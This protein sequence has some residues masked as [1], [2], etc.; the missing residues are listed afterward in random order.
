M[1]DA[2]TVS[3]VPL[4]GANYPTWK[5]QCRMALIRDGL[6]GI[7]A[8][9]EVPPPE[10]NA[11]KYAK[12]MARRDRAL[13]IIVL[14]VDPSLLYLIGDPE[15]PKTVWEK[16]SG[17]FQKKTWANKLS[18][19]KKLF[20]MKLSDSGSMREYIKRM[21]EAFDELAVVADPVSDEDK[22]VYLLAGLPENYDVLVTAL[23]SGSDT[24]P[25]LE[26]VTERLLR[27][28]QKLKDRE[29]ADDGKKLLVAAGRKKFTCHYCKKPG[30]FKKDCWKFAQAQS[31]E[32][33]GRQRNPSRQS[34]KGQQS[35]HN[36]MVIGNALVARS[37]NDW[38][39]DSGATSHMCN[40][41]SMFMDLKQAETDEKVVLGDGN[42]LK[43]A[44]EGTID[45]DMLLDDG[46]T[47]GCALNRVLYV[48]ELAYNLVS[49]SRAAE[50]GKTVHFDDSGCEFRDQHGEV[51]ALGARQG[52]LYYLK[53]A[54]KSQANLAQSENKERLW[55][56]RFGHLNEQSMQK[57]VRRKLVNHLDYDTSGKIGVCEACIGGKQC[58]NSFKPS[59]TATSMPLELV[60]SDVCGKMGQKSIGGAEYFLTLLDDKTHYAWVYPLKTKDQVFERFKE[61]QAEVENFTGMKIKALRTDNG[62]EYTSKAFQAHLKACGIRHEL[63]IPKTPE[64]NGVAERLNRT[65]VETTRAMLLDANLPHKFWAEAVS[66]AVYLRN[67]SPSSA[68]VGTTPHQAWYGQKPR[69]EHLR[70]FGCTAF[71]HIPKDERGKLDSKTRKCILLGYGSVQKGYRVFDHLTQ[72]TSYSRNVKFDERESGGS[73]IEE[74][75]SAQRPLTLEPADESESDQD[76]S[77]EEGTD[78]SENS[79]AV[80]ETPL[81][82]STRERRPVDYYGLPQAH[83]TIHSEP[84]TYDEAINCPEKAKWKNAMGKEMQSLKANGVWELTTLPP[85]K[86]AISCKWVYKVKTN[87]DG[88]IERYKARLV[89]RGFDQKFGSDYDETFCPVIRMESLR[90]L[91]ALSTQR[92]LKLHHVDID[93]AFLNGT[94]EEEVYM[95]QP[96]GYEE[97]KEEHLVCRLKKSIYGLK[98]S[99]RC[100]NT[101]LDAH[102]KDMGFTQL[103]SDPCIYVSGEGEDTFYIGVYVDDLA[104]AGKNEAHMKCVKEELSS[105]F[106]IKDLGELKYFLGMSVVQDQEKKET[107]LGQPAHTARLLTKMGMSD[108]KP[109]KTPTDPSHHLVKATEAE[110]TLDQRLYQSLVGSLMYL[111][112]CTRP[113]IA[114][115]V[116][117]LARFSSKPNQ[118][119]WVAAKRVLRYLKGTSNLG[120]LFRGSEPGSC[121]AYADADWAG[122]VEDRKSTSGYMFLIAGGPVSW[123]SK[124]Q[125]TVALSTAEAEYVALSSATQECVWMRRLNSE[126]GNPPEGPT[127]ILEDNQ[128]CIAMAR[129]PQFHGRAKHI[130][131]KHH[132]VR[133]QLSSGKIELQY[134]PTHEM[135][136]DMLTK[137]LAQQQFCYLREKAGVVPLRDS[138]RTEP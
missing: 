54:R 37:R 136:A 117:T 67:R 57:L 32:K 2:R 25:A 64:Q 36:A 3:I 79:P 16:L 23:E 18:L 61:W 29:D 135:V 88:S 49:V 60:H 21:T 42:S 48:P 46:V 101:A 9:T 86:K 55:H 31:G 85:G 26:N 84:T 69:V 5:V 28:E 50:S 78:R 90:T 75:E 130:D 71:V 73:P 131:I 44:G 22:V 94:L 10:T 119:H 99:S 81:R 138:E 20:T 124:K 115:A 123:R 107:W 127:T 108:C 17:Q 89:A 45:M 8:G 109:V 125:D 132:F 120:I 39:V 95:E 4:N 100:W 111:A 106:D 97:G 70:V 128:S 110:E 96:M 137:G 134:C 15:N 11:D 105:K 74:E 30:H 41:R 40:D 59:E 6:W 65:L 104:L 121:V 52:S 27:E 91:T 63:T 102:L 1:A 12:Y 14:A 83:L 113:D 24:V 33:D 35:S 13:A 68:V 80:T 92:G 34:K 116:A 82:R 133:E 66:T 126:L 62:G 47:R 51:I 58:K 7:V 72:K 56:R 53:F 98:Q 19:R 118:A 103:K 38:I 87:S 43:V 77:G 129:N 112:T 114:Y 93:T 76:E 122:D